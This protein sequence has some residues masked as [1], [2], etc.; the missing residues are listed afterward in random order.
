MTHSSDLSPSASATPRLPRALAVLAPLQQRF[1]ALSA[2]ERIAITVA[3]W[4]LVLGAAW[5]LAVR[6]A[7]RTL[8]TAPAQLAALEAQ[9]Q[10]MQ[11]QAADARALRAL[12]AVPRAQALAALQRAAGRIEGATVAEQGSRIVLT[13][14]AA[15][16]SALR[17]WL[18]EVRASARARP[19]EARLARNEGGVSGTVVVVLGGEAGP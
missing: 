8:R 5:M 7:W 19:I 16:P 10:D 3:A 14:D 9:L 12:P 1:D 6:P 18:Q 17:A 15:P 2:R 4:V 11:A 13:L